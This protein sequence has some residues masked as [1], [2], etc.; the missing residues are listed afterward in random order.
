MIVD[1]VMFNDSESHFHDR[2]PSVFVLH[3]LRRPW[4][5]IWLSQIDCELSERFMEHHKYFHV[6]QMDKEKYD[7]KLLPSIIICSITT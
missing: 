4:Y 2:E 7:I 3:S 1:W 5:I 6:I